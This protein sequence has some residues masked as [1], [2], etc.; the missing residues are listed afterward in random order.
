MDFSIQ[1]LLENG[2]EA[3]QSGNPEDAKGFYLAVLDLEPKNLDANFYMGIISANNQEIEKS[4]LYFQTAIESQPKIE[5]YWL[6]L[7]Q[8][9]IKLGRHKEAEIIINQAKKNST[10]CVN[11]Y[12]LQEQLRYRSKIALEPPK[13]ALNRLSELYSA[14][15][16]KAVISSVLE[17]LIEFPESFLLN[18]ICGVSNAALNN[19]EKAIKYYYQ[20]LSIKKNN[21]EVLFN[22]GNSLK[23]LGRLSEA[24]ETYKNAIKHKPDYVKAYNNLGTVLLMNGDADGAI[25][26]FKKALKIN[27]N[28][29]ESLNNLGNIFKERGNLDEAISTYK[30]IISKNPNYAE[31]HLNM[32]LVLKDQG[33]IDAAIRSYREAL[34]VRPDFPE[35]KKLLGTVLF[36]SGQFAEAVEIFKEEN[37]LES[38]TFLLKC[39][40][41]LD[42]QAK[43]S[44]QLDYLI[45]QNE[46]NCVIGSY[47]SR[48]QSR[49]GFKRS[50]PFCNEPLKYVLKRDLRQVC[51]F[52][53]LFVEGTK[54]ILNDSK[55]QK[56]TQGRLTNGVQTAGNI[57]SQ[58]GAFG[59]NIKKVIYSELDNYLQN[60]SDSDE[61]FIKEW[62]QS[63]TISGWLVSMKSGGELSPH[64]HDTGWITGSVYINVPPKLMI[65]SGNLVVTVED[66]NCV[67]T[68]PKNSLS[69]DVV[70]GN[71]CLF[72]SSLLHY[73]VP[74]ESDQTRIVLAFDVIPA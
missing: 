63:Y 27:P 35:A 24:V 39:F 64:I 62:P 57:F 21:P 32:G 59:E 36:Q 34:S 66:S 51:N 31:A 33:R 47:T 13:S 73:T 50:N 61:G 22:I 26:S 71:L 19:H 10:D 9:F 52:D 44:K 38:Q 68:D 74:F 41:Q 45:D 42:D 56:R 40:Y 18:N 5:K 2:I 3:Q 48:S 70:T 15:Q 11:I 55:V 7:I 20:A 54:A 43:F 4:L 16:Y 65:D 72:P 49:Y 23:E 17:L 12:K 6:P 14:N 25:E 46:L 60:F 30:D 37:S 69:L 8:I 67:K 58:G 1:K 28:F 29:D 53:K